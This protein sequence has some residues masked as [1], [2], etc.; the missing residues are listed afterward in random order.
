MSL[1]AVFGVVAA[2]AFVLALLALVVWGLKRL[3]LARLGGGPGARLPME[4]V[5][6]VSVG[7]KTAIAVVRVGETVMTVSVGEGGV[8]PLFPVSDAD[9]DAVLASSRVPAPHASSASAQRTIDGMLSRRARGTSAASSATSAPG[10]PGAP[11]TVHGTATDTFATTLHTVRQSDA[12]VMRQFYVP[13]ADAARAASA[14][15]ATPRQQALRSALA[16]DATARMESVFTPADGSVPVTVSARIAPEARGLAEFQSV[17]RMA[18][19]GATRLA[20][21]LCMFGVGASFAP[22]VAQ[23]AAQ[24]ATAPVSQPTTAPATP[25][26][27]P[28]TALPSASQA[29]VPAPAAATPAATR[30]AAAQPAV[31]APSAPTTSTSAPAPGARTTPAPRVPSG[32]PARDTKSRAAQPASGTVMM[33][34][35]P[36]RAETV[37][38]TATP[39]M[40][41]SLGNQANGDGL[42]VN[43]TVGVVLLM[44]MLT[45]LPTLVLMMTGFTRILIVLNFLKQ[46]MGTQNA[47]PGQLVAALALILT[48]FVMAPTI[49]QANREAITPWLDGRMEQMEMLKTASQPFRTFMLAQTRESDLRTFVEL[50]GAPAPATP[51]DIPLV[52]LMSAFTASELRTAFQIGFAIYLPFIV[53]DA[54]VASVLMSM[55]MMMLPPAMISMP[56]KLLLF[57]LV[58]GWSLVVESLVR[59]FK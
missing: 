16:H 3:G 23:A 56:F 1:G 39:S 2:L 59:S 28:S 41:V 20:V 35:T 34:G 25:R 14:M 18:L 27:T 6:R 53:I 57:V 50:S 42:Q 52:T 4:I 44:G 24:P 37:S 38:P 17:L 22:I 11:S 8:R 10:A 26:A 51:A 5:Q 29:T 58:D 54:V 21:L 55:G 33:P 12:E 49:E 7:P 47:P 30:P 15:P 31:A 9:R 45:L 40:S 13:P 32:P 43:G 48:G 46:A 36:P 19:S